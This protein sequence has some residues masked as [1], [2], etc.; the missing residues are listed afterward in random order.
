MFAA[1]VASRCAH[2]ALHFIKDEKNLVLVAN[3]SQF[4]QP[5]APE[6]I[7]TAFTLNRFDD[8]GADIDAALVYEVTD[9]AFGLLFARNH[10]GFALRL[11]QRKIDMWRRDA[12]PIELGE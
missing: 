1:P 3:L 5:F 4:Q 8:N 9:F 12:R 10:I 11:R 7:V 6:M 2:A